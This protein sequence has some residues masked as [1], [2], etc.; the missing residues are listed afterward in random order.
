MWRASQRL[1]GGLL[2]VLQVS[3]MGAVPDQQ[4]IAMSLSFPSFYPTA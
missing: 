3:T 2:W 4:G 1:T